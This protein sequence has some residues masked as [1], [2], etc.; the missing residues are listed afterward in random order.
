LRSI[1]PSGK[2]NIAEGLLAVQK[3]INEKEGG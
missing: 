1:Q 3:K 2:G